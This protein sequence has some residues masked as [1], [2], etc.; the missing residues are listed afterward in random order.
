MRIPRGTEAASP[1]NSCEHPARA[2]P[3]AGPRNAT[4][5]PGVR[6]RARLAASARRPRTAARNRRRR[7]PGGL[8]EAP[9]PL[10]CGNGFH[11]ELL[12]G[13]ADRHRSVRRESCIACAAHQP[14]S[15]SPSRAART[16]GP[17]RP[18]TARPA[19]PSPRSLQ[20][21]ATAAA[22]HAHHPRHAAS[23]REIGDQPQDSPSWA[24][25]CCGSAATCG[26]PTTP[27]CSPPPNPREWCSRS[28]S[29][30][31]RCTTRPV[32]LARPT[33]C[34]RCARWTT[35]STATCSCGTVT[36]CDRWS[37]WPSG[38]APT[39]CTSRR[40]TAGTACAGTPP[41]RRPWPS[42]A[43][44]CTALVRRTPSPRAGCASR[45]APPTASSPRSPARGRNTAGAA[46][47]IYRRTS[48]TPERRATRSRT[49]RTSDGLTLPEAGERAA[50]PA[51][52]TSPTPHSPATTPTGTVPTGRAPPSSPRH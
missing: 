25:P 31:P 28:S 10:D 5:P 32:R 27:R 44:R 16:S 3:A 40:T 46:R 43:S 49:S 51:G 50:R 17:T 22:R 19:T 12:R 11:V 33:C 7:Q 29:S 21:P 14:G 48:S 2:R 45:T 1:A 47:P 41:W 4:A 26:S 6:H 13:A 39:R 36:R 42:T 23:A 24:N 15:R 9:D 34:G 20:T 52:R 8:S 18:C 30:T 37:R 38:P 35:P